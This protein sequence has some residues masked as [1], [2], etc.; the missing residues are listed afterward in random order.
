MTISIPDT[1]TI[2]SSG[3]YI[4]SIRLWSGG[5]SFSAYNPEKG[6]SFFFRETEFD[7]NIPYITSLKETFFENDFFIRTYRKVYV[8]VVSPQY[9]L[10]PEEWINDKK[11]MELIRLNFSLPEKKIRDNFLKEEKAKVIFGINEEVYEFCSRSLTNPT[12][13]HHITPQIIMQKKQNH[14]EKRNHLSVLLHPQMIDIICF[15]G[16]TLRF[17]NSFAYNQ[18]DD[19]IYYILY[20][21]RQ[22]EMDQLKDRLS[23]A[24]DAALCKKITQSLNTYIQHIGQIEVPS[25]AYL[26]GGEILHAPMD[27]VLQAV[28]E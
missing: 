15:N 14:S 20:V 12:F 4:M 16:S 21:W 8:M 22:M 27:L 26:L 19:I 11:K 7:R 28:C 18:F 23:L 10:V 1:F 24:G 6:Q 2:E 25:E 9:T 13:V 5:L 3:K 17:V